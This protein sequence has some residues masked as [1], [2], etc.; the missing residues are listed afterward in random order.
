MGHVEQLRENRTP[1]R[2]GRVRR[3]HGTELEA[4]EGR[5][6][7]RPVDPVF[8]DPLEGVAEKGL[9]RSP[10]LAELRRAMDLLSDIRKL[11]VG[12]K[13]ARRGEGPFPSGCRAASRRARP[14]PPALPRPSQAWP[15]LGSRRR[16]P[17]TPDLR[18]GQAPRRAGRQQA[19]CPVAAP[20]D[21][22]R[23]GRRRRRLWDRARS[24]G[25]WTSQRCL[26]ARTDRTHCQDPARPLDHAAL[27]GR[28]G[29]TW[30]A[31]VGRAC[32]EPV[33]APAW[34]RLAVSVGDG[35]LC[36]GDDC[37]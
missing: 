1:R 30:M 9:L 20:H 3:E 15:R 18:R 33:A 17:G 25:Y 35:H 12:G 36:D 11:E 13:R 23:S 22:P 4:L 32:L 6:D 8:R 14:F 37:G 28:T 10:S 34:S 21:A 7:P 24:C 2:L 19:G 26:A 31:P 5:F 29:A 16:G 27:D